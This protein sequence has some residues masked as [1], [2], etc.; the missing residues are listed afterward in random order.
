MD[1]EYPKG[2]TILIYTELGAVMTKWVTGHHEVHG[3]PNP[4]TMR[5]G[6]WWGRTGDC[7]AAVAGRF[8]GWL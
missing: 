6:W 7:C 8:M 2:W 3:A 1:T 5:R 4:L